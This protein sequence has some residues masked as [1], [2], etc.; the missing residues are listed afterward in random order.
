[1]KPR[2]IFYWEAKQ[3]LDFL[4]A[5]RQKVADYYRNATWDRHSNHWDDDEETAELRR[6]INEGMRDVAIATHFVGIPMTIEY[7][8]PAATGGL[9]G[10]VSLLD[11]IFNF[12]NLRL[13]HT[14]LL[15]ELDRAIGVYRSW[16]G[17]L[18]RQLFNPFYWLGWILT[19]IAAIPFRLLDAAGFNGVK[20][21]ASLWGKLTKAAIQAA[22]GLGA[23]LGILEKLGY[24]DPVVWA[25]HKVVGF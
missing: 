2:S 23:V 7:S 15:D 14:A 12:P 20:A 11:N 21:E 24:L 16:I 9:A 17:P 22:T 25:F 5:Y 8:P 19:W 13:P 3:R 18:W 4:T 6:Q 10:T 1:M